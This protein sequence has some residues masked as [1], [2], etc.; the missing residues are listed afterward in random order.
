MKASNTITRN[1]HHQI[2][3]ANLQL[4]NDNVNTMKFTLALLFIATQACS[5]LSAAVSSSAADQCGELGVMQFNASS[6]PEGVTPEDV[7]TCAD[8]PYGRNRPTEGAS[9]APS[10][11]STTREIADAAAAGLLA[12]RDDDSCYYKAPYGCSGGYCWKTC[13]K[14]SKGEWCWTAKLGGY[15][16]WYECKTWADCGTTTYSCGE[17]YLCPS[18]GC[19]C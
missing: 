13:S 2:Y 16:A 18:C 5:V 17:G 4:V 9:Y 11:K 14:A 8:H 19:G 15:G 3:I 1:H 10:D 6:L 12:A 7:R